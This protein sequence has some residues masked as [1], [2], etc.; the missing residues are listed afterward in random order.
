MLIKYVAMLRLRNFVGFSE[1]LQ[2]KM[3]LRTIENEQHEKKTSIPYN[4]MG[5]EHKAQKL[6]GIVYKLWVHYDFTD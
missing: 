1:V 6:L 2:Q 5:C 3:L 4:C